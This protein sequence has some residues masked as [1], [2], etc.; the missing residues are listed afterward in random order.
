[1][2]EMLNV[3]LREPLETDIPTLFANQSDPDSVRMA[4][5][6]SKDPSDFDAYQDWWNRITAS[7]DVTIRTI[8]SGGDIVGS[9]LS[10]GDEVEREV[11][12]WIGREFWGRGIATMALATFLDIDP[13]RPMLGRTASDNLGS[14]RVMEKCGF[15]ETTTSR[16]F[17]NARGEEI[18]EL[19]FSMV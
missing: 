14:R 17:A 2:T 13:H 6:T 12:Y 7:P 19:T 1:M 8:V 5:F 11:S 15:R 18:E 9:V 4:A 3:T 10:Y 16:G